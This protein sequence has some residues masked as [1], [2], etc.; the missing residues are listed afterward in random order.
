[1]LVYVEK[2][3]QEFNDQAPLVSST[4]RAFNL[5]QR[6]GVTIESFLAAMTEAASRTREN[7]AGVRKKGSKGGSRYPGRCKT[8]MAY[9]FAVLEEHL[10][11]DVSEDQGTWQSRRV[12]DAEATSAGEQ[13][14]AN[15]PKDA[16]EPSWKRPPQSGR[17]AQ[18]RDQEDADGDSLWETIKCG[19]S[20]LGPKYRALLEAAQGE[21]LHGEF[22]IYAPDKQSADWIETVLTLQVQRQLELCHHDLS[23]RVEMREIRG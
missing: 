2:C 1:M 15:P 13:S 5:W 23:V 10:H 18:A 6:S 7:F 16:P 9:Y 8:G 20:E 21:E 14:G 3:A 4:S 12:T 22:V 17:G 11:Q 19:L